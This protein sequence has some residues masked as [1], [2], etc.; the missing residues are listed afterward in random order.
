MCSVL[1]Q[2]V[3]MSL[4]ISTLAFC[5]KYKSLINYLFGQ[6]PGQSAAI[7][8][9][10]HYV[11]LM[12]DFFEISET[13]ISVLWNYLSFWISIFVQNR[14]S[15]VP[16]PLRKPNCFLLIYSS[17]LDCILARITS[18]Q[19]FSRC[20]SIRLT[21]LYSSHVVGLLVFDRIRKLDTSHSFG[22]CLVLY[23]YD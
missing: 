4:F 1:I 17:H 14:A 18:K 5:F 3:V 6:Y 21:D 8:W 16:S 13:H 12:K 15:F 2:S 10:V 19:Y 23:I 22:I 11:A 7:S 9:K 20:D